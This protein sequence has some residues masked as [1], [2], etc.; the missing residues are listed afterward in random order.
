MPD[1]KAYLDLFFDEQ[2]FNINFLSNNY[3]LSLNNLII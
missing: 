1:I 2:N 3:Y